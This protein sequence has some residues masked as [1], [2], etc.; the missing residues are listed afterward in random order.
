MIADVLPRRTRLARWNKK[1]RAPQVLAANADLAVCV[2]SP[3]VAS[4]SA[5]V[6]RPAHRGGGGGRADARRAPE[7]VRSSVPAGDDR[8][9]RALRAHGLP[10]HS[11][12]ARTGEG[13]ARARAALDGTTAVFVGQSG[14]GKSSLLNALSP[15]LGS[16]SGSCPQKHDRG[17]HTTNFSALLLLDGGLRIIDTPGVRELE[18]A[19]VLPEEVGFPF[20]G[21]HPAHASRA[22]TSPACTPTSRTARWPRPW[23]AGRSIPTATR[24]T[25]GSSRSCR[26]CR[27]AGPW[28]STRLALLEFSRGRRRA[29]R[30]VREPAG[31]ARSC[32]GRRSSSSRGEAVDEPLGLALEFRAILEIGIRASRDSIFPTSTRSFPR[33][34]KEGLQLEGEEL[35]AIGR[36]IL[37]G[38]QAEAR[39]CCCRRRPT[40]ASRAIAADVPDLS[41]LSRARSSASSTTRASCGRSRSRSSPPS[42]SASAGTARTRTAPCAACWTTHA[43]RALL[44]DH[45]ADAAR[46]PGRAS[47]EGPVQG[48]GEGDRARDVRQRLHA[49]HRAAGGRG[50]EQRDRAGG[51]PLPPGGAADPAGA[52]RGGL[53]ARGGARASWCRSVALLDTW[54]AR[55][56]YAVQHSCRRA[57]EPSGCGALSCA[58]PATPSWAAASFPSPWRRAATTACSSSPGRTRAE[59]R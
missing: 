16:A 25:C 43:Y 46:R 55:A 8:A 12:S 48:P 54:L 47:A 37:S 31:R 4:V 23:R 2:T 56:R 33:L 44:A 5:A 21:L 29:G 51:E 10:V 40:A 59:R 1:G 24:A 39:S 11:C 38:A 3:C 22:R 15:G 18:L 34:G 52:D 7:Q 50:E 13:L 28:M 49:L 58:T 19:D 20:P 14:V 27:E 53:R 35:A 45:H 41:A 9:A 30:A 42:G 26:R 36:W 17:N 32:A 6:H 57:A